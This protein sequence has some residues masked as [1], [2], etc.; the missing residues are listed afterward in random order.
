[1]WTKDQLVGQAFDEIAIAGYEF[2]LS[3]EEKQAALRRMDA[4]VAQWQNRGIALGYKL[5]AS[6][7][8]SSLNDDSG[9]PD[10]A[11]E[12]V[13]LNLAVRIAG[14]K[15]KNLPAQTLSLAKAAYDDL[16][17]CAAFPREQQFKDG[18]PA[19]AGNLPT[20]GY[21]RTFLPAPTTDPLG[22]SQ[23]GDLTFSE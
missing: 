14:S 2:D 6:P 13:F 19:G 9:I 1:M 8:D 7:A 3:P 11:A 23:G 5:P 10:G 17:T 15:G 20:Y 18:L 22:T 21:R 12:A 16:L 4:M